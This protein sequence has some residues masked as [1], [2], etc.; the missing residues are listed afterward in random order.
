LLMAAL[1]IYSVRRRREEDSHDMGIMWEEPP[2]WHL[3][4][5]ELSR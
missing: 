1:Y 2:V 5:L 4:T 3:Q